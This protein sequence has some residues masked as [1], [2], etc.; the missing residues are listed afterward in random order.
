MRLL[1]TCELGLEGSEQGMIAGNQPRGAAAQSP[2]EALQHLDRRRLDARVLRQVEIIVAREQRRQPATPR[3]RPNEWY[4]RSAPAQVGAL[5]ARRAWRRRIRQASAWSPGFQAAPEE[6]CRIRVVLECSC[7]C[8]NQNERI[9]R[10]M[11]APLIGRITPRASPI[12]TAPGSTISGCPMRR[13]APRGR[14]CGRAHSRLPHRPV[15]RAQALIDGIASRWTACHGRSH[16]H[17]RAA[18]ERQLAVMPHVVFRG[19][20][21]NRH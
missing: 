2:A 17:I 15:R 18:V 10:G 14:R 21:M 9:P 19:S 6:D 7:R 4:R 12:G 16:P 20:R 3:F 8:A 1:Q 5:E 11:E 13:C